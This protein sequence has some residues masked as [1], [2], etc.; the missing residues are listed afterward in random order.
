MPTNVKIA[1]YSSGEPRVAR[2]R[3]LTI[4]RSSLAL[5]PALLVARIS[6]SL[7]LAIFAFVDTDFR[8]KERLLAVCMAL[9]YYLFFE[10]FFSLSNPGHFRVCVN[11]IW[12]AVIINMDRATCNAFYTNYT[13]MER[14]ENLTVWFQN[15]FF[16]FL[17][18]GHSL[19][20]PNT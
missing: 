14:K 11:H 18:L 20:I 4:F 12:Y 19:L 9:T 6:L 3:E 17:A 7:T 16:L 10:H 13:C 1:R 15:F 2:V 5:A 8:A